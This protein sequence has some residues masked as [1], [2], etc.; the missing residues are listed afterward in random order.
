MPLK[1]KT[2]PTILAGEKKKVRRDMKSRTPLLRKLRDAAAT[3][4]EKA[5]C[6]SRKNRTSLPSPVCCIMQLES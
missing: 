4:K 2:N 5:I 6:Q 3:V 1:T